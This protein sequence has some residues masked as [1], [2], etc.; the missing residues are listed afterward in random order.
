MKDSTLTHRTTSFTFIKE[1]NRDKNEL[2]IRNILLR[3]QTEFNIH[4]V[5]LADSPANTNFYWKRRRSRKIREVFG[6]RQ[7][8]FPVRFGFTQ[9]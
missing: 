4:C 8:S 5:S 7:F 6:L 2:Y 9:Y 1:K 3:C